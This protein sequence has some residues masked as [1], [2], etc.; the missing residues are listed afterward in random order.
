MLWETGSTC[1][2][3]FSRRD[4]RP[5]ALLWARANCIGG[6]SGRNEMRG[7]M[8]TGQTGRNTPASALETRI[9][10]D[11][12]QPVQQALPKQVVYTFPAKCVVALRAWAWT[13]CQM[14]PRAA[15]AIKVWP[16]L[17]KH[18]V[19][20][21]AG[22]QY[23]FS[24]FL[25]ATLLL[26]PFVF[27]DLRYCCRLSVLAVNTLASQSCLLSPSLLAIVLHNPSS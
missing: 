27:A 6:T 16:H 8:E 25:T 14:M 24:F 13:A 20:F 12:A 5:D 22:L 18:V 7:L 2:S 3:A 23:Y 26:S 21:C 4:V 10:T 1:V 17:A 15:S 11:F 19:F 9:I